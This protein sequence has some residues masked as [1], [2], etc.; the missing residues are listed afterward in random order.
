MVNLVL[1]KTN[2]LNIATRQ[3]LEH[4]NRLSKSWV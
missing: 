2:R 1:Q 4:P 3:R